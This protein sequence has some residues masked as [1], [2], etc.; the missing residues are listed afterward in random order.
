MIRAF[1]H[2]HSYYVTI[3]MHKHKNAYAMHTCSFASKFVDFEAGGL[4]VHAQDWQPL[5]CMVM[6]AAVSADNTPGHELY[7]Y[8]KVQDFDG[9]QQL[10]E[11]RCQLLSTAAGNV[12]LDRVKGERMCVDRLVGAVGAECSFTGAGIICR[13]HIA[14]LEDQRQYSTVPLWI[15][16]AAG[17]VSKQQESSLRQN[18]I[19]RKLRLP[20]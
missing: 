12:L 13:A 7:N 10:A 20:I 5:A 2:L 11:S 15:F 1:D 6:H 19:F 16:L 17:T 9:S 3:W 18:A 8:Y 4:V 14:S